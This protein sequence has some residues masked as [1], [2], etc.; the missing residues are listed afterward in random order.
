MGGN[1][2]NF[3][4]KS[5]DTNFKFKVEIVESERG[6]GQRTDEIKEFDTYEEARD[7]IKEFNSKNT[8]ES[9]PDWYM[10]ATPINFTLNQK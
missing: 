8:E 9:V 10:Y 4:K 3:I 6:W 7:Y 5:P 1:H 2:M